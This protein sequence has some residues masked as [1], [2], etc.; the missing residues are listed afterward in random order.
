MFSPTSQL[1]GCPPIGGGNMSGS[2]H[3]MRPKVPSLG[4]H[5]FPLH[6]KH[7]AK[8]KEPAKHFTIEPLLGI[9]SCLSTSTTLVLSEYLIWLSTNLFHFRLFISEFYSKS[10]LCFS[11][12][13]SEYRCLLFHCA[14]TYFHNIFTLIGY[15]HKTNHFLQVFGLFHSLLLGKLLSSTLVHLL[16]LIGSLGGHTKAYLVRFFMVF[17]YFTFL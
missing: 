4:A 6:T 5:C 16:L 12:H 11:A 1:Q 15:Y 7:I 13:I 3:R 2:G 8:W 17:P 10:L 9:V 14:F